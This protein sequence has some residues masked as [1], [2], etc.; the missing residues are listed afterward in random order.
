MI[1]NGLLIY[2]LV[3]YNIDVCLELLRVFVKKWAEKE[4]RRNES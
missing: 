2:L 4:D 1:I 3:Y